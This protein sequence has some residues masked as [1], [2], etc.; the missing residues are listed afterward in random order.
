MDFFHL[1]AGKGISIHASREGGDAI[2]KYEP[3]VEV[4]FNPRLPRG[5]RLVD[6]FHLFAGK[7][8]SIHASREGGDESSGR[9][10]GEES[11]SIHASREGGDASVL[12]NNIAEA[13][14]QSTPPA[15]EATAGGSGRV[16]T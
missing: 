13:L 5:R 12:Y 6:F 9:Q 2:E 4:D 10:D 14:F 15:R 7:G 16:G 11:I 8:I 1:F 3:R